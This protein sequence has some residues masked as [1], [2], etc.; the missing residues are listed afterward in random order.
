M[1]V[2]IYSCSSTQY[3][4]RRLI[5]FVHTKSYELTFQFQRV[6]TR[7][8]MLLVVDEQTKRARIIAFFFLSFHNLLTYMSLTTIHHVRIILEYLWICISSTD[9]L[10]HKSYRQHLRSNASTLFATSHVVQFLP[11]LIMLCTQYIQDLSHTNNYNLIT[12]RNK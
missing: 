12:I 2:N 1:W 8:R 5:R 4:A 7:L 11:P 9:A 6:A 10:K 3:I